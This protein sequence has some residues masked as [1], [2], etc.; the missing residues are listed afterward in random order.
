MTKNKEKDSNFD[1]DGFAINL[2]QDDEQDWVA[3]LAELPQISA[4][5]CTPDEALSELH[6]AWQMVKEDYQESGEEIPVAP[7]RKDYSGC[8][9]IR[10]DKRVHR[11]LAVE[12]AR[13]GISL[14][15]LVSQKL[16]G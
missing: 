2:Y 15:A 3:H 10:I 14:N 6:V 8:F 13:A 12:A 16:S 11:Q 1:L 9:N 4:F 7:S 5:G